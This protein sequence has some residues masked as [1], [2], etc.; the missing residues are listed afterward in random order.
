MKE[1]PYELVSE[2]GASDGPKGVRILAHIISR[3]RQ[4]MT[5]QNR[6][7]LP[8]G[9]NVLLV[10]RQDNGMNDGLKR[11][12]WIAWNPRCRRT[13]QRAI[14]HALDTQGMLRRLVIRVLRLGVQASLGGFKVGGPDFARHVPYGPEQTQGEADTSQ[15]MGGDGV[16]DVEDL[17]NGEVVQV[18]VE[19]FD[20]LCR[21]FAI[22]C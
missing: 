10:T 14:R 19:V 9:I 6:E 7:G 18:A 5:G 21:A 11:P 8:Q 16:D 17:V 3:L 20:A 15:K 4:N 22:G 13:T 12:L 2:E 1:N